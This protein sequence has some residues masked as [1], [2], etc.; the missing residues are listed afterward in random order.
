MMYS[1]DFLLFNDGA[2]FPASSCVVRG[3]V[4]LNATF[5]TTMM[6]AAQY[7]LWGHEEMICFALTVF[8]RKVG[9]LST[10][11]VNLELIPL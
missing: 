11:L 1:C 2:S 7:N 3:M 8:K 4:V 10:F 5:R 6:L 9:Y